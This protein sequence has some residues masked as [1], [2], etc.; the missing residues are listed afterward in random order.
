M[1]KHCKMFMLSRRKEE[2]LWYQLRSWNAEIAFLLLYHSQSVVMRVKE[3]HLLNALFKCYQS[4]HLM[5]VRHDNSDSNTM[6]LLLLFF[7]YPGMSHSL[8]PHG[9]QHS[10]PPCPPPKVCPSSCQFHQF[11]HP[12]ISSSDTLFSFWPQSVLVSGI[13]PMSWLFASDNQNSGTS[14]P[15]LPFQWV[16]R[17]DFPYDWLVWSLCCPR[18]L[19]E[20]SPASQ[21]VSI[22]SSGSAFFLVQFSEPYMTTEKAWLYGPFWAE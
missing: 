8:Q 3:M 2:P 9:L 22:N 19:Q 18:D 16:F 20:C 11:C 13:F 10:R 4:N 15:A 14:A 17:N 5:N 21:F 1:W 6:L 7:S 12:S